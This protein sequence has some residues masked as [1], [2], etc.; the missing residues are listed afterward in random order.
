MELVRYPA[1]PPRSFV[2]VV[3]ARGVTATTTTRVMLAVLSGCHTVPAVMVHAGRS[4]NVCHKALLELAAV[5]LISAG[6]VDDP[7][8]RKGCYY[9]LVEVVACQ[10]EMMR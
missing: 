6:P 2:E 7:K 8:H 1:P 4:R 3:K 9:P 5:G 10:P